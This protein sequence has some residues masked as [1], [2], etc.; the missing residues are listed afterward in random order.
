MKSSYI[1]KM[2]LNERCCDYLSSY[3]FSDGQPCEESDLHVS[4]RLTAASTEKK[5]RG[6][7]PANIFGTA[8]PEPES[9]FRKIF[10]NF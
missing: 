5:P 8:I 6:S 9:V 3:L 4:P 2:H 10:K 7:F 1:S